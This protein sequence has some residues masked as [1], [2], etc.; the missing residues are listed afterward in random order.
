M[1][2]SCIKGYSISNEGKSNAQIQAIVETWNYS[3]F[4]CKNYILNGLD[5]ILDNVYG[6]ISIT[7]E[8]WESLRK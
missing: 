5:N 6:P 1:F 8:L 4:M 3:D 7:K 2:R